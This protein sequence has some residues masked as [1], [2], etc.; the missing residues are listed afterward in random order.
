MVVQSKSMTFQ[1]AAKCV[2]LQK[3]QTIGVA[4][5]HGMLQ[6]TKL[7]LQEGSML[8]SG[9]PLIVLVAP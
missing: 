9:V 1:M 5:S 2:L 4:I 7:L 8:M 6:A 3:S